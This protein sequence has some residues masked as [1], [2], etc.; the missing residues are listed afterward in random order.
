MGS[1]PSEG[2]QIILAQQDETGNLLT[3]SIVVVLFKLLQSQQ[4]S[5]HKTFELGLKRE[6]VMECSFLANDRELRLA[7]CLEKYS[8]S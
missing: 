5:D 2:H 6:S 4:L 7:S 1:R 3:P 8:L